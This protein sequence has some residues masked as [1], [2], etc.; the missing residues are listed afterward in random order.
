MTWGLT[1][2]PVGR[3][4][5]YQM[6]ELNGVPVGRIYDDGI[7]AQIVAALNWADARRARFTV[8]E[9]LNEESEPS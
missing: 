1:P 7:A 6:L 9:L 8:K 5:P 2:S 4:I 3:A